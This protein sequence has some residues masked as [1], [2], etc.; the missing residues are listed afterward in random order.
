[1]KINWF[2]TIGYFFLFF[3][4]LGLSFF[5]VLRQPFP[6]PML[7]FFFFGLIHIMIR[8]SK[9]DLKKRE[10]QFSTNLFTDSIILDK[11][12]KNLEGDC[13]G[14]RVAKLGGY[15]LGGPM[16]GDSKTVI[17][18]PKLVKRKDRLMASPF[19]VKWSWRWLEPD[20]QRQLNDFGCAK[21]PLYLITGNKG[22]DSEDS[23][24][25]FEENSPDSVAW[26]D[27][28][29]RLSQYVSFVDSICDNFGT[30]IDTFNNRSHFIWESGSR[31]KEA[32]KV[33]AA[34]R[35]YLEDKQKVIQ[36][37]VD[38]KE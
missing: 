31:I 20:L 36:R 37:E 1:M 19:C 6:Y 35:K 34:V 24:L 25:W 26:T 18:D 29:K 3:L 21:Y 8:I 14:L 4:S 27:Y 17:Y 5:D 15:H 32:E 30:S 16:G 7:F 28:F 22:I 12:T 11:H 38:V 10:L 33:E 23:N 9:Q 13:E 2:V